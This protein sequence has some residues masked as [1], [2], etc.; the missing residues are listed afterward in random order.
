MFVVQTNCGSIAELR[1][2]VEGTLFGVMSIMSMRTLVFGRTVCLA[3]LSI[4]DKML[5]RRKV[6]M[7]TVSSIASECMAFSVSCGRLV[8]STSAVN[9]EECI[10]TAPCL[11]YYAYPI[12]HQYGGKVSRLI[13]SSNPMS[14][15]RKTGQNIYGLVHVC[16][17]GYERPRSRR[18]TI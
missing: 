10:A 8:C 1:D 7:Q 6:Q 15:D 11:A 12:H 5:G 13:G 4:A 14:P 17:R 3:T 16:P 2:D 18:N 9:G